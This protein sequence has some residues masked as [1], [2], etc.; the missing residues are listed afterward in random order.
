LTKLSALSFRLLTKNCHGIRAAIRNTG[1]GMSAER[2]PRPSTRWTRKVKAP[3]SRSGC[4][5]I[6]K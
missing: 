1:Y 5:R 2:S 6:Q 3:V 4:A